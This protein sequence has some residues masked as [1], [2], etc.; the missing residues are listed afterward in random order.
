MIILNKSIVCYNHIKNIFQRSRSEEE[1]NNFLK[2]LNNTH[3]K[4]ID[5]LYKDLIFINPHRIL[6]NNENM[7]INLETEIADDQTDLPYNL[8]FFKWYYI[9]YVYVE[10]DQILPIYYLL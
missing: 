5:I 2:T 9:H 8:K 1:V 4:Y 6:L 10:N 3:S 7:N